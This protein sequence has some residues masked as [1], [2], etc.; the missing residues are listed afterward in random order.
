MLDT[1]LAN[2]Y[3]VAFVSN[4]DNLGAELDPLPLGYFVSERLPFLMEV[5]DRTAA[6]R[7]GG[8]LAR[9]KS[10]GR[11]ALRESAQC[12]DE[13]TDAFQDVDRHRYFN[14]NNLWINLRRAPRAACRSATACS[15]CR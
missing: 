12:P 5:A 3:E 7:K 2:G 9:R 4:A 11:L 15:A 6:D 10:D 8:H 13:D 14:T 1:L